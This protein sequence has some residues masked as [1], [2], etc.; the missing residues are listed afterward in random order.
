[1][2]NS[3]KKNPKNNI[4]LIVVGVGV[5]VLL[6][7]LAFVFLLKKPAPE[8]PPVIIPEPEPVLV[9][10]NVTG[11]WHGTWV[12]N[13]PTSCAGETGTWDAT[14][15]K[16]D[17]TISGSYSSD[18]GLGGNVSGTVSGSDISWNIVG[19][20]G[21]TFSGGIENAILSGNFTGE[22]CTGNTRTTGTFSGT[23]K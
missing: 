1:M 22:V 17:T 10:D 12:V 20:G 8:S 21:V 19:S 6:A 2:G 7:V 18:V 14:L 3:V 23:K 11:S 13:S 15:L 16:K 4:V 5:V 9:V